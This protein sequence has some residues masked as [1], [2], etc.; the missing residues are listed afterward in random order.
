MPVPPQHPSAAELVSFYG[1]YCNSFR[2]RRQNSLILKRLLELHQRQRTV[3]AVRAKAEVDAAKLDA[4]AL[5]GMYDLDLSGSYLGPRGVLAVAA[6][7]THLPWLRSLNLSGVRWFCCDD[8][9]GAPSG[10]TVVRLVLEMLH[11]HPSLHTLVLKDSDFS[12]AQYMRVIELLRRSPKLSSVVV[13]SDFLEPHELAH[14]AAMALRNA[15]R[16]EQQDVAEQESCSLGRTMEASASSV[17]P[18]E[19]IAAG[20]SV[21]LN[22]IS[23]LLG[24]ASASSQGKRTLTRAETIVVKHPSAALIMGAASGDVQ[25]PAPAP[26][27]KVDLTDSELDDI[28]NASPLMSLVAP[29][30]RR[31]LAQRLRIVYYKHD[32]IILEHLDPVDYAVVLVDGGA[33][34]H[35]SDDIIMLHPPLSV[36]G[37]EEMMP[38]TASDTR[39][40]TVR[41]RPA[42]SAPTM[43]DQAN[44]HVRTRGRP[45]ASAV[46]VDSNEATDATMTCWLVPKAEFSEHV[47][48]AAMAHRMR[49]R[50]T[51]DILPCLQGLGTMS[52]LALCDTV[53]EQRYQKLDVVVAGFAMLTTCFFVV[54][55]AAIV[56]FQNTEVRKLNRGDLFYCH[57][58]TDVARCSVVAVDGDKTVT[59]AVHEPMFKTLPLH[60]QAHLAKQARIYSLLDG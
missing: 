24:A 29:G 45:D 28:F 9:T 52:K 34:S 7:V 14:V 56:Y 4:A 55:G 27:C 26:A 23:A 43:A 17:P 19:E 49:W 33:V 36:V 53:R 35:R 44:A 46:A 40:F 60:V 3:A 39:R 58:A 11:N 12:T 32:E 18:D 48:K 30:A 42:M 41:A 1:R 25:V 2:V 50:R 20:N 22:A 15:R 21:T 5:E 6:L 57:P 51:V 8:R 54:D 38:S 13:E 47:S 37:E 16:A 31:R 10:D 59:A